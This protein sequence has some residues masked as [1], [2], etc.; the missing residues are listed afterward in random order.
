MKGQINIV[1]YSGGGAEIPNL[2][3]AIT[4]INDERINVFARTKN[5][6]FDNTRIN[7]FVE[8]SM[9]ADFVYIILYGGDYSCPAI[10]PVIE[11]IKA[12]KSTG[13]PVPYLHIHPMG[14]DPSVFITAQEES[15]AYNSEGW[16]AVSRYSEGG[17]VENLKNFLISMRSI[18]LDEELPDAPVQPLLQQGIYHPDLD[19]VPDINEYMKKYHKSGQPVVGM[20]FHQHYWLN[21]NLDHID[22][23][24]REIEKQGACP[25]AIF[26]ERYFDNPESLGSDG[27]VRKYF[28]KDGKPIIH[29]LINVMTY[30]LNLLKPRYKGLLSKLGVPVMQAIVSSNSYEDWKES[31]QGVSTMDVVFS[32][33][34]PEFDGVLVTVNTGTVENGHVDKLTGGI[35]IKNKGIAD[36]IE[37]LARMTLNWINLYQKPNHEKKVAVV[38]HHYPP[39]NDKIGSAS[40]LDSFMSIKLLIDRMKEL[41]YKI[42]RTYED[43]DDMSGE[44]LN[45][46]TYDKRWLTPEALA[47]RSEAYAERDLF[48]PWHDNM[49]EVNRKMMLEQWGELP[50]HMFTYD[51]RMNFAGTVNGNVFIT[52]QPPRGNL[53]K[54]GEQMHDLYLSPTH[55][56]LAK[57][58]WIKDVFKADAVIHVG[59]HGSLEWLPGKSLGLSEECYPDLAITELPNIYPYLISNPGEGTQAKRRSFC[60]IIDHLTPAFT[61]SGL[62]EDMEKLDN[63]I[64]DYQEAQRQERSKLPVIKNL[65]WEAAVEAEINK[66]LEI[67]EDEAMADFDAFMEKIHDY[68]EDINDT[69]IADGLHTM[70]T[71]PEGERLIEFAAQLTRLPNGDVPSLR[72]SV[73]SFMGFDYDELLQN[74]GRVFPGSGGMS[75][76][77]LIQKAHSTCVELIRYLENHDFSADSVTGAMETVLHTQ[78]KSVKETLEYVV[79]KLIPNIKL[80]TGE[81]N[82]VLTALNG[83]YVEPGPSGAPSRG[84]TDILPTGR[85]FYSVDPT[86]IPTPGAWEIGKSLG[87]ALIEKSM[88]EIGKNPENVAIYIMGTTT[89]RTNGDCIAEILYLMGARPIWQN[90]GTVKGVEVI[91]LEELGRPRFDVTIRSTGFFRDSFP[92]LMDLVNDAV[93]MISALN[94]PPESNI[95]RSNILKDVDEYMLQGKSREEAEKDAKFRMFSCPPG[96]YGAGVK[97]LVETK[98]WEVQDDLGNEYIRYSSHA[99]DD[100]AGVYGVQKPEVFRKVLSRVDA[101]IQN[102]DSRESD[103]LLC[104]DYYNYYGG[105]ITAVKT[106]K[107]EYPMSVYG[108]SSDPKRVKVRTTDEEAK[109]VLRAR[110][111]N[112][113][114]IKGLQRHGYKGAGDLSHMMDVV[115]G[116]DACAEVIDDFMYDRFSDKYALDPEMQKWMKEVNPYALQNILDKLLEA[117]GRGMWY[118]TKEREDALRDAYLDIEGEIEEAVAEPALGKS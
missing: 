102:C 47:E 111:L 9:A 11:A 71:Y 2:S 90:G 1:Y 65:V 51:D 62:Y 4:E 75:G 42:E 19:H 72:E 23:I 99:Y 56:Y 3:T 95:L 92:N 54:A 84:N 26:H 88:K 78:I 10:N 73:V 39:R 33:A 76:G 93:K 66:D 105:L 32:V 79:N 98:R 82:S 55:H 83:R 41:G 109:H 15:T 87:D 8:K 86:K 85:N 49:P 100:S 64:R 113:K 81:I 6:I 107:G 58:R 21:K 34:H 16:R 40:G 101:T 91:P 29:A 77:Q 117:I 37:K 25:L 57:Y 46:M 60:C 18:V 118:T 112:P 108:D 45:R 22:M 17:G 97:E 110:V 61:N 96:T 30:S 114:W 14:D 69:L 28:T 53:E 44:I 52:M 20:W 80:T 36:R 103:M 94:E 13:E 24:I 27:V 50:G 68:L 48:Q 5:Q 43:G 59:T 31:M 7:E 116:W 12:K 63:A 38:F 35:I 106:V 89:M 115:L 70:G 67:S 74:R 104:T